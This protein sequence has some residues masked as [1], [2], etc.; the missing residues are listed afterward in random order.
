M[1]WPLSSRTAALM[2]ERAFRCRGNRTRTRWLWLRIHVSHLWDGAE[3]LLR[4]V[5][6]R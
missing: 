6:L 3:H 4:R 5:G 1:S 2:L